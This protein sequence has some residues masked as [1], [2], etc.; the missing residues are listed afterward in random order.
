MTCSQPAI[1]TKSVPT[2]RTLIPERVNTMLNTFFGILES[3]PP[4]IGKAFMQDRADWVS[5]NRMALQTAR[6]TPELLLWI[7]DM[8]GARDMIRWVGNYVNFTIVSL[9]GF[10]L[11]WLPGLLRRSQSWLEPQFPEIW[12]RLLVLSYALTDGI[13]RPQWREGMEPEAIVIPEKPL[14]KV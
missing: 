2:G 6:T 11:S 3:Q 9:I 14:V 5:F 4:A 10:L 13:G 1:S 7:W 12:F 8:A